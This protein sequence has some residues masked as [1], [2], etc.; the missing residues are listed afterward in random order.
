MT[1]SFPAVLWSAPSSVIADA[2]WEYTEPSDGKPA[3]VLEVRSHERAYGRPDSVT[4]RFSAQGFAETMAN[5][6]DCE[7]APLVRVGTLRCGDRFRSFDGS[8]HVVG[9]PGNTGFIWVDGGMDVFA[10]CALVE[11]LK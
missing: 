4:A 5:L 8:E 2:L 9:R 7:W 10:A 3:P 6:I 1:T 11:V